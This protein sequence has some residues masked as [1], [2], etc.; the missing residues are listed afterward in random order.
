MV[1]ASG[2]GLG[3]SIQLP[4]LLL[5][6]PW[7]ISQFSLVLHG[8][9]NEM[10]AAATQLKASYQENVKGKDSFASF[11]GHLSPLTFLL[12]S[13]ISQVH[14]VPSAKESWDTVKGCRSIRNPATSFLPGNGKGVSQSISG[15]TAQPFPH[16]W[17]QKD[18]LLG[19]VLEWL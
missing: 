6:E 8:G 2:Q 1:R 18:V 5:S 19:H 17:S 15:E 11:S 9:S 4:H 10:W 7:C 14:Q 13:F 12:S 3:V 16:T